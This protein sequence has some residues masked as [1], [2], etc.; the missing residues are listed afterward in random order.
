MLSFG[1]ASMLWWSLAAVIPFALHLWNR[2]PRQVVQFAAT[3]FL[4]AAAK[5]QSRRLK[6]QQWILLILRVAML[7]LFALALA[8]P[9]WGGSASST[10]VGVA[11]H[12]LLL[13]DDSYSMDTKVESERRMDSAKARLKEIVQSAPMGDWFSLVAMG[14]PAEILIAGP[15]HDR[16][17]LNRAI[18]AIKPRQISTK[19]GS[20][21]ST[22]PRLME[23][24]QSLAKS[25]RAYRVMIATDL[26]RNTWGEVNPQQIDAELKNVQP[27]CAWSLL[28]VGDVPPQRNLTITE[29]TC[30]ASAASP[31]QPLSGELTVANTGAKAA[32]NTMLEIR[33]GEQALFR[34]RISLAP[35]QQRSL[36]WRIAPIR[37]N[38]LLTAVMEPDD[39]DVD[40]RRYLAIK[41]RAAP[42]IL[43]L[44]SSDEA[45][46]HV[47]L[48][49]T[50]GAAA[51]RPQVDVLLLTSSDEDRVRK[52]LA[53]YDAVLL[54]NIP[55]PEGSLAETLRQ[56]V[57]NGGG[58]LI[59]L[60][61]RT[62]AESMK[63]SNWYP[64]TL[65]PVIKLNA[66]RLD[67][68]N[69]EHPLMAAFRDAPEVGLL[70]PPIWRFQK[71]EPLHPQAK[72]AARFD[73]GDPALVEESRGRGRMVLFAGS[74]GAESIDPSETPPAPWSGLP[75]SAAYVPIIREWVNYCAAPVP[76]AP[77]FVGDPAVGS[78]ERQEQPW[79]YLVNQEWRP[80]REFSGVFPHAG[81]YR[82]ASDRSG[83]VVAVN[84]DSKESW[85]ASERERF[86]AWI[87]ARAP[88]ETQT[89]VSAPQAHSSLS[90]WLLIPLALLICGEL[91]LATWMRRTKLHAAAA[92]SAFR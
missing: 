75:G 62:A 60:G 49:L 68:L 55:P 45:A 33:A 17:E 87:D 77:L 42:R 78:P 50:S 85:F 34:E 36:P 14:Q 26:A 1:S 9:R 90:V 63:A 23:D 4:A 8:E 43:C 59:G 20:A 41:L 39:L 80:L 79:E 65:G 56:Y 91:L 35:G 46:K 13:V 52:R 57:E 51:Q 66:P 18:D 86:A 83:S 67:P 44:A 88:E 30:S 71:L 37:E 89:F 32:E 10:T 54:L 6:F 16:E 12:H 72:I 69:Y 48:A 53:E 3:R 76:A 47:V 64:A 11:T 19:V 22:V 61:D 31:G 92:G 40:N 74:L 28:A 38:A 21:L 81:F 7:L 24:G 70:S 15:S 73:N 25:P 29:F 82:A 2:R 84:L 58:I 5:R 27:G